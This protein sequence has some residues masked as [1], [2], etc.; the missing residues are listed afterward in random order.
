MDMIQPFSP[1]GIDYK[2]SIEGQNLNPYNNSVSKPS[3]D[4][5]SNRITGNDK[6]VNK[7][8]EFWGNAYQEK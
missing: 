6:D 4:E 2:T 5:L 8:I 7:R 1:I 3:S